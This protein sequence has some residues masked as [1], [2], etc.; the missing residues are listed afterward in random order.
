[1]TDMIQA[2]VRSPKELLSTRRLLAVQGI[3][4]GLF[5]IFLILHLGNALMAVFGVAAYNRFQSLAQI[6]YQQPLVEPLLVFLPLTIHAVV[7]VILLRRKTAN[8]LKLTSTQALNSWAG[9]FLL[10]VV[11]LHAAATRGV[12]LISGAA[13]GFDAVSFSI[14]WMPGYFLPYYFLLFM[15]GLFHGYNGVLRLITR[16]TGQ[17]ARQLKRA[18]PVM[19]TAGSLLVAISLAGFAGVRYDIPDPTRSDY[20][21]AYAR[22]FNISLE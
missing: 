3:A 1:M 5:A 20:A 14:W 8:G 22:I 19:L 11:F 7:G 21:A 6:Y 12:A 9:L 13:T 10:L 2:A 16:R 18:R 15:A 17:G 4:G